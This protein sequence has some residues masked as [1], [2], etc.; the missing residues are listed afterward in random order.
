MKNFRRFLYLRDMPLFLKFIIV[1]L[2]LIILPLVILSIILNNGYYSSI[3]RNVSKYQED[4]VREST[5][6]I[7]NYMNEFK[8]LSTLPYQHSEVLA[9]IQS[10]RSS[11]Q[12]L[13]LE[14]RELLE[15]FSSRMLVN[16]R[17][18][19]A[20]FSL[21]GLKGASYILRP[22]SFVPISN[23][24][25]FDNEYSLKNT[26]TRRSVFISPH[27]VKSTTGIEYQ[28]FSI[29]R[30]IRSLENGNNLGY[31]VIDI[32]FDDLKNKIDILAKTDYESVGIADEGGNLIYSNG[33]I[34]IALE[35]LNNYRGSGTEKVKWNGE[36]QLLT[37]YT[38][39]TTGW[40][41]F[42]A[43][44]MSIL[45]MES[46]Q[47]IST[48]VIISI[49]FM[50][51]AILISAWLSY[52]IT[53]PVST[54]RNL[55]K[56]VERGDLTVVAPVLGRDEIGELSR[57]FNIMVSR[58][59]ELGYLLYESE[60]REKNVQIA[61]LQSQINPH[62]LYNTL[63]AI[64]MYAEI[65]NNY[66]II[67]ITTHL[68]KLLR[69]SI[70][71]GNNDVTIQQ[72]IDHVKG[73][74]EIQKIR[75]EDRLNYSI[76]VDV[77]VLNCEIV[78]LILQPIVENV[79][80]HGFDKGNGSGSIAITVKHDQNYI[81]VH[82]SDNGIGMSQ[83]QLNHLRNNLLHGTL[84]DGPGGHGLINVHRRIALRYGARFGLSIESEQSVGTTVIILL[85]YID[86]S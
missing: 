29:V 34:P 10:H 63:G 6:N 47:L 20:G 46:Q 56:K 44:P 67:D 70:H 33:E 22:H 14:E 84:S 61:A 77:N 62:F 28:V 66:E 16:G 59:S 42:R 26:T 19:I 25:S 13:A 51:F 23:G 9:F 64:N 24:G 18:N 43:V 80:I 4:V 3:Q 76:Y 21:Y 5:T 75:Y 72:E 1:N 53:S 58:L 2:F 86:H 30:K 15:T 45:L 37:Y 82:V 40:T 55:M 57:T 52:R 85:P 71:G 27:L 38:S 12:L 31:I 41:T 11:T 7:D 79:F 48:T 17:V 8:L 73:Y 65:Q 60:I 49:V 81:Y 83:S 54:L 36:M 68:G 35:T 50:T 78:R 39:S 32:D 69:Y 74:L